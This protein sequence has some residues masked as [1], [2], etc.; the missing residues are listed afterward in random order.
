MLTAGRSRPTE[1]I[2]S[3][4]YHNGYV[5]IYGPMPS[6]GAEEIGALTRNGPFE[7]AIEVGKSFV[8]P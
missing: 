4:Y 3:L 8:N 6:V 1:D 2:G 5:Q 7:C